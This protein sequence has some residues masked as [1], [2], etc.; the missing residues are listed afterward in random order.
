MSDDN[1]ARIIQLENTIKS[2]SED[3]SELK[4]RNERLDSMIADVFAKIN[5]QV[6]SQAVMTEKMQHLS[7]AIDHFERNLNKDGGYCS[8]KDLE[9][10]EYEIEQVKKDIKGVTRTIWFVTGGISI[11][12]FMITVATNLVKNFSG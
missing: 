10:V 8:K 7:N 12:A 5:Q 2:K 9:E 3:I 1:H 11:L 4:R 6:T